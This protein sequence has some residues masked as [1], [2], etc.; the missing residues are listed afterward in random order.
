M[1]HDF[2]SILRFIESDFGIK[3]G[4]LNF[5]D[6]RAQNDLFG[7]FNFSLPPRPYQTIK[8]PLPASFFL[9][10]PRPATDPDDQ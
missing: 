3:E 4:A 6:A 5:A 2:G 8:A 9:S 10:D 7:F 1:R